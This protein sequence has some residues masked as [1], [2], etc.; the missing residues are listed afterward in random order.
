MVEVPA[1]EVDADSHNIAG[2]EA[3]GAKL[4]SFRSLMPVI[5]DVLKERSQ[6][7][8]ELFAQCDRDGTSMSSE[9]SSHLT[10]W[11]CSIIATDLQTQDDD[12]L[13]TNLKVDHALLS[14]SFRHFVSRSVRVDASSA[15]CFSGGQ[16]L[17]CFKLRLRLNT[18][19]SVLARNQGLK[20]IIHF[21]F[22]V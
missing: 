7:L 19:Q 3:H 17:F 18:M 12:S 13:I 4:V 11:A 1:T 21:Q 6:V 9:V 15:S 22:D 5:V 2:P 16:Q 14:T 10:A 8:R 20:M